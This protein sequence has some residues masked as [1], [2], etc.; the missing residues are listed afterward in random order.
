MRPREHLGVVY[1]ASTRVLTVGQ[2]SRSVSD[3]ADN[4][5]VLTTYLEMVA[6]QRPMQPAS[7]VELRDDDLDALA[8]LLD[9]DDSALEDQ[10][11]RLL[12]VTRGEARELRRRMRARWFRTAAAAVGVGVFASMPA[13]VSTSPGAE[14]GL[15]KAMTLVWHHLDAPAAEAPAIDVAP[16]EVPGVEVAPIEEPAVSRKPPA[17]EPEPAPEVEIGD[18]VTIERNED[19]ETIT[20]YESEPAP[21]GEDGTDI[22]TALVIERTPPPDEPPPGDG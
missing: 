6:E 12:G 4:A 5:A 20:Y 14:P 18:A 2:R 22:G 21:V 11:V 9:L 3:L 17:P 16:I 8:G 19:G 10:F 15:G 7:R 1:D 13:L